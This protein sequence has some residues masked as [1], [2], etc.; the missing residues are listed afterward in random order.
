MS[1]EQNCTIALRFDPHTDRRRY[2][3]PDSRVE[4]IAVLLPGDGDQPKDCQDVILYCND[5][6]LQRITDLHPFYPAL[7]YV[8]L[9][10]TGQLGWH[11]FIP[12]EELEDRQ[13]GPRRKYM[14]MAEFHRFHL[15][16]RPLH[17]ESNHL[18][19]SGKLFQEYVCETWAVSEQNRLNYLR[20]NQKKLRVEVYQGL[21]DAVA[22]DA[23]VNLNELGKRFIL[24]SSF[25]GST[26]NM[27]QHCQDALA[28]NR[29]LGG[30]DLFITMTAN[31]AWPE[32][33]SALLPGQRASDRPDL[34]VWVFYAKLQS[35]IKDIKDGVVARQATRV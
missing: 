8:L 3:P 13:R 17:I 35:L 33:V 7:H 28:I 26:R 16:P 24:P 32:I 1:P 30:G 21:Q 25:S 11:A 15:F 31:P 4:E 20:R 12:Y 19:L 34:E 27:Q 14:S 6:P 22:A 10:P 9:H 2:L 18:F 23:D 5:G 29:Y